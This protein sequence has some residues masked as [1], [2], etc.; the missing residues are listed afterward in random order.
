MFYETLLT[1]DKIKAIQYKAGYN[2]LKEHS[3]R[4]RVLFSSQKTILEFI[5]NTQVLLPYLPRPAAPT[6]FKINNIHSHSLKYSHTDLYK[7]TNIRRVI[8]I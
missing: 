6:Q 2:T 8:H 4:P 5:F 3:P 1:L 7:V